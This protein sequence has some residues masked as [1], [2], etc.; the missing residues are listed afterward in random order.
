MRQPGR[1]D[2]PF[3]VDHVIAAT[4]YRAAVSR[5]TFIDDSVRVRTAEGAPILSRHFEYL[6]RAYTSLVWPRPTVLARS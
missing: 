1:Q 2:T 5:L 4:R 3:E 6:F